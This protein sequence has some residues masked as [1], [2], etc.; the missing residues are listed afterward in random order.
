LHQARTIVC[1][2]VHFV[3]HFVRSRSIAEQLN[4]E[5]SDKV[6]P[7]KLG[8]PQGRKEC[9]QSSFLGLSERVYLRVDLR[10][11]PP[12]TGAMRCVVPLVLL[13][14]WAVAGCARQE[15]ES[16]AVARPQPAFADIS[17]PATAAQPAPK[18]IVTP[19]TGLTGRIVKVN[20]A[21]RFVILNFP[22]GH[23]PTL[24]Q[25]LNVYHL[26]LK[27]GEVKVTGQQLDDLVVGDLV[28]GDAAIGDEVRA[29]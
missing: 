8:P 9:R 22:V 23:L 27:V 18:L 2:V 7:R 11:D 29:R 20:T 12:F 16:P 28:T 3:A 17:H 26:G 6:F 25:H 21:G 4:D 5:V 24:E 10:R 15:T 14:L 19:E 13:S 1:F